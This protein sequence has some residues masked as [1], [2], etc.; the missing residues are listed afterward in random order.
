MSTFEKQYGN[1][2]EI[3]QQYG[4]TPFGL[5]SNQVWHDD[6]KRLVFVLSRYKFVSKQMAGRQNVLEIGCADAF[7]TRIVR[8]AV[9]KVTAT[10][11]DP[12]FIYDCRARDEGDGP[13]PMQYAVHDIVKGPMRGNFD[14]VFSLDVFEHIPPQFEHD[15]VRN[16]RDSMCEQGLLIVG[17]PSLESQAYA[18]PGSKEGHVN[19][20]S[21]EDFRALFAQYFH[22]TLLFS[23]SD[24]VVHTGFSK[25]AN[26]LFIVC[27]GKKV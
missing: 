7:G 8:Q 1:C 3:E 20:K 14:G 11:I 10:D 6:P 16:V 4:R 13:W 12:I 5:M 25:M 27:T 23:M 24:E 26:Y 17:I 9:P 19:C 2:L 15:Y 21:G 18:S 22:T